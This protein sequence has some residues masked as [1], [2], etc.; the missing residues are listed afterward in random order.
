MANHQR[1]ASIDIFRALTMLLMIFVNDLWTLRDIPEW[2]GHTEA[3]E[4]GMGLA[5]VVFPA[6]LFIVGL[7]VPIALSNRF[8]RE[9]SAPQVVWHILT[10]AFALIL[11]GFFMVNLE[12]INADLLP[13][14]RQFWQLSMALAIFLIW[15]DY[16][17][18]D[19]PSMRTVG[20]LKVLGILILVALAWT[21]KGGS[22]EEPAWMKPH[23]WGILGLIG[24]SYLVTALVYVLVRNRIWLLAFFFV[25]FNALNLLEVLDPKTFPPTR[26]VVSA[27]NYALTMGGVL[28]SVIMVQ[29]TKRQQTVYLLLVLTAM[30]A[31]LIG[32]GF[33]IRPWGGISKILATPAWTAICAGISTGTLAVLYIVGDLWKWRSVFAPIQPAGT[34]TLTCYLV[35]YFYYPLLSLSG[36]YLPMALRT[37]GVGIVKSLLFALLIIQITG[38]LERLNIRL[39]I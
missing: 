6:F 35:P 5:D 36:W 10:R 18:P 30:S 14:R 38:L 34:S 39:K 9:E 23:W 13:F 7:S 12:N 17:K 31:V 1:V 22:A 20:T 37:G 33:F 4:D 11:M 27:S 21:Y 3:Q 28:V 32:Y 2:L 29:L 26:L 19:G 24:W 25:L 15:N 16:R 8:R